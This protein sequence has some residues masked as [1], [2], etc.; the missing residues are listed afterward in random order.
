MNA[1]SKKTLKAAAMVAGFVA[2]LLPTGCSSDR[3]GGG[4]HGG[5]ALGPPAPG[6]ADTAVTP[7]SLD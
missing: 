4:F 1:K 7:P 5:G 6:S 3:G 2:V